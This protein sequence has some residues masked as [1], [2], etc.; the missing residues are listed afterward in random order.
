MML[1]QIPTIERTREYTQEFKGYNHNL[2][3]SE[4][5][6]Y[7]EYN[8]C[9]DNY[10]VLSSRKKRGS[11]TMPA[12]KS[13]CGAIGRG[14]DIYYVLYDKDEETAGLYNKSGTQLELKDDKK[15][16]I[17]L[18][19]NNN[20]RKMLFFGA[21]LLILPD[22]VYYNTAGGSCG[23]INSTV[24]SA[25]RD[26]Q[27]ELQK[28]TVAEGFNAFS[29]QR[30]TENEL[31]DM[32][33]EDEVYFITDSRIKVD[34]ENNPN[35]S[36]A[37]VDDTGKLKSIGM[38]WRAMGYD[39][40]D[41]K[42]YGINH[43]NYYLHFF[44]LKIVTDLDVKTNRIYI[45]LSQWGA[46]WSSGEY[47]LGWFEENDLVE[48]TKETIDGQEKSVIYINKAAMPYTSLKFSNGIAY[49]KE[50]DE[51]EISIHS[52][53]KSIIL[54][55]AA[56]LNK[57]DYIAESQNRL[58]ACKYG[59]AENKLINEIYATKLGTFDEWD[60]FDSV[61]G[62]A[63]TASVGSP[64]EFTGVA[65][66]NQNPIFFKEDCIHKVYVSASGA[67]QIVTLDCPG[68]EAGSEKSIVQLNGAVIYKTRNDIV[69]FDGTSVT[70]ISS[71]L[72][73]TRYKNAIAGASG[74][75]Y[76]LFCKDNDGKSH[77]FSYDTLKGIWH[78]ETA[79]SKDIVD[80]TVCDGK[81]YMIADKAYIH[82]ADSGDE[83]DM[84]FMFETGDIGYGTP[85]RKYISRIDLRLSLAFGSRMRIWMQYDSDGKWIESGTLHGMEMIPKPIA[86]PILP[87]RCDHF[88][89]KITGAGSFNLYSITKVLENGE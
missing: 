4:N 19:E 41:K 85:D 48:F 28:G 27:I 56:D 20:Q 40:G 44:R 81:L 1:P 32:E 72:G 52:G 18:S 39:E 59:Q 30:I 6:F 13:L 46:V 17:S 82:D 73:Y 9:S 12:G 35:Q 7:D 43:N 31:A 68:V 80:M 74:S 84:P 62:G 5:E 58:W 21:Y 24:S 15:E 83:N 38:W 55:T 57:F 63:Y 50:L 45:D 51:E 66:V 26:F 36:V 87:R 11:G 10:P 47:C 42:A 14:D 33:I 86:L 2:R 75:K 3:I 37:I 65:V 88:R 67:H 78:K 25:S 16:E 70:S 77:I 8:I 79:P 29:T 60:T 76:V 69:L 64:G 23:Y 49:T 22:N 61:A 34:K 54:F 53:R 71:A 89:I